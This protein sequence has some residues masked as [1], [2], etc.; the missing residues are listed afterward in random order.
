MLFLSSLPYSPNVK[1]F[2]LCRMITW[3]SRICS[4]NDTFFIDEGNHHCIQVI[5]FYWEVEISTHATFSFSPPGFFPSRKLCM[6]QVESAAFCWTSAVSSTV[7]AAAQPWD[8]GSLPTTATVL[9]HW[10]QT[11]IGFY[12]ETPCVSLWITMLE[13]LEGAVVP[14]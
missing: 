4:Y 3:L 13:I 7:Y 14:A 12:C 11:L 2:Y 5:Y 9:W 6:S 1:A 10:S 8:H